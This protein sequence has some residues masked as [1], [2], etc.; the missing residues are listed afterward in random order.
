[1][2]NRLTH[3]NRDTSQVGECLSR[4]VAAQLPGDDGR[5]GDALLRDDARLQAVGVAQVEQF[6]VVL[7]P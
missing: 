6:G 5:E 7:A 1:M 2:A 4:E 3:A